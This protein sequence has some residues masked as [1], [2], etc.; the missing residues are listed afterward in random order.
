MSDLVRIHCRH[1][2]QTY[3]TT[4]AA[5]RQCDLCGQTGGLVSPEEALRAGPLQPALP[6]RVQRPVRKYGPPIASEGKGR[7]TLKL[8]RDEFQ[9]T[10]LPP[11]CMRCGAPATVVREKRF[12]WGP[13]WLMALLLIGLLCSGPLFLVALV[14]VPF[15]LRTMRV[16]I[17]LCG[18]HRNHWIP[19]NVV[20]YGGLATFALLISST[21]TLWAVGGKGELAGG[22]CFAT[23]LFLGCWLIPAAV[24]QTYTI[25]AL[26]IT[27]E[28]ITL[29]G[30]AK[31]FVRVLG[32]TE[33]WGDRT[34]APE[35][36]P[37]EAGS[38]QI[39]RPQ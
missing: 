39:K 1:C 8:F 12:T 28:S 36:L 30:V 9:E 5:R 14:L 4:D 24:L 22:L 25:R 34:V 37:L 10:A 15:L 16:P 32:G 17:P 18:R 23:F 27:R 3:F 2:G 35:A 11:V 21:I 7:T 6:A 20:L 31:K 33:R 19:L 26:E 29:A 38:E 13:G